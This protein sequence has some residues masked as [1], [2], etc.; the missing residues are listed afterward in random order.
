[1][2]DKEERLVDVVEMARLLSW[3]RDSLYRSVREGWLP[4]YHLGS[5]LIR[6]DPAEVRQALKQQRENAR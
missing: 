3:S 1:V 4:C 6:F 2:S 5:R